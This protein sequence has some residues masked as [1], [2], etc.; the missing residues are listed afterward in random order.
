MYPMCKK[1]FFREYYNKKAFVVRCGKGD[2]S[3][4]IKDIALEQ[5]FGL[6]L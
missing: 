3:V 6:D 1:T 2:P 5:M 4:R